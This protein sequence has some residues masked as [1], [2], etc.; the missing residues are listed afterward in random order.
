M[1]EDKLDVLES[2]T[3]KIHIKRCMNRWTLSIHNTINMIGRLICDMI[4]GQSNI[5]RGNLW[6]EQ[7]KLLLVIFTSLFAKIMQMTKWYK[8]PFKVVVT[9]STRGTNY[10]ARLTQRREIKTFILLQ[11]KSCSY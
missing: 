4:F 5:N 9:L 8:L 2:H 11:P 3:N 7:Y 1:D 6:L 10:T